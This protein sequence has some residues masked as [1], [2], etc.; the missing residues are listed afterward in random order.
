MTTGYGII[1]QQ[2]H[3]PDNCDNHA[4]KVEAGNTGRTEEIEQKSAHQSADNPQRDVEPKTLILLVDNLAS[5]KPG[6]QAEYDPA[7]DAMSLLLK[8]F[9]P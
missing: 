5:D 2:H 4:V 8:I 9:D 6:D 7:D 1:D 3:N